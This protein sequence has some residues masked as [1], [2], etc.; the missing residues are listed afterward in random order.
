MTTT[1]TNCT[2]PSTKAARA[3]CRT[4]AASGRT[5][6]EQRKLT[7]LDNATA[8]RRA[9][10]DAKPVDY[11][12]F[13]YEFEADTCWKCSGTGHLPHYAG[14]HGGVCYS[15]NGS[16]KKLTRAGRA[17][18][19]IHDEWIASHLMVEAA[20]LKPGDK[21]R[22]TAV[23]GWKTIVEIDY[24]ARYVG[25]S[26]VGSGDAAKTTEIYHISIVSQ[27]CTWSMPADSLVQRSA[28]PAERNVLIALIA[29]R[30]GTILTAR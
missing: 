4:A 9:M 22:P 30:K 10:I 15:C 26:T 3:L 24:D 1:H 11:S 17:A 20:T 19:K 14:I 29:D 8:S 12:A 2:H 13:K 28:T 6:D 18:K 21:F 25:T 5:H 23:D 7:I 16:G 27:K